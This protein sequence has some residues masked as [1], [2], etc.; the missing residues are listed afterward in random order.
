MSTRQVSHHPDN[1]MLHPRPLGLFVGLNDGSLR[2]VGFV[3]L[4]ELID[5]S[6]SVL[7]MRRG[8]DFL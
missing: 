4:V 1:G 3:C 2:R 7:G 6:V 5:G 8:G